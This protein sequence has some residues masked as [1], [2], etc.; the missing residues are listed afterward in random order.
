MQ[1][2]YQYGSPAA[3]VLQAPQGLMAAIA[4]VVQTMY[5]YG[6]ALMLNGEPYPESPDIALTKLG[7]VW[8]SQKAQ[9]S[10]NLTGCDFENKYRVFGAKSSTGILKKGKQEKLFKCTEKSSCVQRHCV[11]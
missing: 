5:N 2:T 3:M 9:Y 4:P 8:V 6:K 1:P 10:E 7:G 11:W